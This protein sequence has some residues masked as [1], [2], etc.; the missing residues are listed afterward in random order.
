MPIDK[1]NMLE[2]IKDFPRQC[3]EALALTK[4]LSVPG[5][6]RNIVVCGMGGSAIG[7]DLL[8]AYMNSS[9]VPVHVNRDYK[10]PGFV[11]DKTLVFA[12][13]YSGNTEETLSSYYDAHQKKAKIVGISSGGKLAEE[14]SRLIKIPAGMQPRAALGYLFFPMLGV[15]HN[16][17]LAK[18]RN[19]DLNEMF[20]LLKKSEKPMAEAEA[21]AKKLKEKI[22]LIYSSEQL[23]P[24]AMR[25]KTQINENAKMAAFWNVFPEMNHNEIAA[26]QSM[27]SKYAPVFIRDKNDNERVK[28]RMDIC[29]GIMEKRMPVNEVYTQGNSLLARMFSTIHLGDFL[30]YNLALW[31]RVDPNPVY[32]IE[33]MK[34]KLGNMFSTD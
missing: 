11:N 1:G 18:V 6:I 2:V 33:D 12:V 7:G 28:K 27:D 9:S 29:K 8:K 16:A 24:V 34:K 26:Y 10:V 5:E 30:S 21:L 31:N 14:C 17:N 13:S 23:Y 15:I 25:W 20:D 3:K 19:E 4:G 22:P 32:I